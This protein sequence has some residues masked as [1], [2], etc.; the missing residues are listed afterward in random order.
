MAIDLQGLS[1]RELDSLINQAKQRKTTLKKRKPVATVRRKLE[2]LAQAEGYTVAELFGGRGAATTG[3]RAPAKKAAK[4]R[5]LGKVA[6]KY[7]NPANKA[8]TWTGRGKQPRWL[9]AQVKKGKKVEDFLIK[10]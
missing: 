10:K 5:K 6:P 3:A 2:A 7:R 1:A 4:G 8:E 9:A